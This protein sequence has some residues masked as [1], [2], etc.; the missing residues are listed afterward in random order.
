MGRR[1]TLTKKK[2]ILIKFKR[3]RMLIINIKI[4]K[5]REIE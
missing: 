1:N 2:L 5:I 4:I 3:V